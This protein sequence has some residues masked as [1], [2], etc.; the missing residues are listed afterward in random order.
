MPSGQADA[1]AQAQ[2]TKDKE[3][4]IKKSAS[5]GGPTA[6]PEEVSVPSDGKVSWVLDAD[7]D[8]WFVVMDGASPFKH[9]KTFFEGK[10]KGSKKGEKIDPDEVSNGD[11]F[12]Y[13]IFWRDA[14][15]KVGFVDPRIVIQD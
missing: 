5:G 6:D 14:D 11:S 3:V 10:G 2:A 1:T 4:K 9:H 12:K 8:E 15:G 13:W 7:A